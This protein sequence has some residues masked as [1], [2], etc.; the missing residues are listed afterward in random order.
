MNTDSKNVVHHAI[1]SQ[2]RDHRS[3]IEDARS[4]D[5]LGLDALD[6]VLVLRRIEDQTG[7]NGEF[8]IDALDHTRTVGEL[9]EVVDRWWHQEEAQS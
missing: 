6:V 8:F 4:F 9:V 2:V 1:A 5:E 3:P 7:V